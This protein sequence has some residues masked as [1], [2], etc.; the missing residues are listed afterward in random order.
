MKK[1]II[2]TSISRELFLHKKNIIFATICFLFLNG[3]YI[4]LKDGHWNDGRPIQM[5][6]IIER[7]LRSDNVSVAVIGGQ[8]L[9][10]GTPNAAGGSKLINEAETGFVNHFAN[11]PNFSIVNRSQVQRIIDEL[12]LSNSGL[13]SDNTRLKIGELTGATHL[14]VIDAQQWRGFWIDDWTAYCK[15]IDI[16]SGRVLSIDKVYNSRFRV[17]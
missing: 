1:I 4:P 3:C 16:K 15:L 14:L 8:I 17:L 9:V 11:F 2:S 13:I 5:Y 7:L 10:D 6:S 12:K